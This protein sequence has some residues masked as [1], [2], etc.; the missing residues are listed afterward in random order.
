MYSNSG[1][2]SGSRAEKNFEKTVA[3]KKD[4]V[5]SHSADIQWWAHLHDPTGAMNTPIGLAETGETGKNLC[6]AQK[7]IRY[8]LTA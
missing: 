4:E 8:P 1:A 2:L 3:P 5:P 7:T 6:W